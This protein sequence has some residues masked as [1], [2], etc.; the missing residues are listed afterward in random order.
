LPSGILADRP[1]PAN[2]RKS[3]SP[4]RLKLLRSDAESTVTPNVS[5]QLPPSKAVE[6]KR[7]SSQVSGYCRSSR[8]YRRSRKGGSGARGDRCSEMKQERDEAKGPDRTKRSSRESA[9]RPKWTTTR[10]TWPLQNALA[11]TGAVGRGNGGFI[12][13]RTL[14]Q[15]HATRRIAKADLGVCGSEPAALAAN[16]V[17]SRAASVEKSRLCLAIR[18]AWRLSMEWVARP[19]RSIGAIWYRAPT[20]TRTTPIRG[21]HFHGCSGAI[22]SGVFATFRRTT[23]TSTSRRA[24]WP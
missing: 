19:P 10:R 11:K 7:I 16:Q 2:Q 8:R 24:I 9:R 12:S 6:R 3:A 17:D 13:D 20:A 1:S 23:L 15:V 5:K 14:D 18:R 21:S 22:R 4:P